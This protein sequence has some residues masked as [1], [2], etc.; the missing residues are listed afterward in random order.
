M[1]SEG[2]GMLK[3][4]TPQSRD[5]S[6]FRNIIELR[7]V[8]RTILQLRTT[9][10]NLRSQE[11]VLDL[12]KL[13]LKFKKKI[14][15]LTTALDDI[16]SEYLAYHFGWKQTYSDTLGL[17]RSP[18]RIAK[19][20]NLLIERNGKPTTYRTKRNFVL[21]D[22]GIP[23][24]G[25]YVVPY[26]ESQDGSV[27]HRLD[28]EIELRMM[29]NT[30][31]TFPNVDLPD[32]VEQQFIDQ[33]GIYPRATDIYNL[34]PW[35]WLIDWFSGLGN[36]VEIIDNINHDRSLINYGFLTYESKGKVTSIL[37]T[38]VENNST[39]THNNISTHTVNKVYSSHSSVWEYTFQ[40][41]KDLAGILDVNAT[42]D[43]T[44]LTPYQNSI[45]GAL[46]T[47]RTSF[48]RL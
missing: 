27:Q 36:Y 19:K 37:N 3:N 29:V 26:G 41:R 25:D 5:Y 6:L 23:G 48:K 28:R 30:T 20:I 8:P 2:L 10:Q 42:S 35:T 32:F 12:S 38:H 11:L 24:F 39:I 34:V 16:P 1:S 18:G 15:S 7:D 47:Q 22:T 40:R 46:L 31:F 17:L 21:S 33:L 43:P 9:L 4:I 13:S 14:F 44:S 45:L